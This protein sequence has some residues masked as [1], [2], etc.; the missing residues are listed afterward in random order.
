MRSIRPSRSS[1]Q[2]GRSSMR[3]NPSGGS[4]SRI[5]SPRRISSPSRAPSRA[6]SPR[7]PGKP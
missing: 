3:I 7:R 5:S 6:R 2:A 1:G 4:R